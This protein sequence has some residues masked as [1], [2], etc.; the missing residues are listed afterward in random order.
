MSRSIGLTVTTLDPS[1]W[2]VFAELVERNN[3]V[4]G[5]C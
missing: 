3:G 1:S 4:L 5:G 2:D